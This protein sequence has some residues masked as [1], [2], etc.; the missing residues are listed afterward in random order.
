MCFSPTHHPPNCL[1]PTHPPP[2]IPGAH[3]A[4]PRWPTRSPAPCSSSPASASSSPALGVSSTAAT[5]STVSLPAPLSPSAFVGAG[6]A[7]S[8]SPL[9]LPHGYPWAFLCAAAAVAAGAAAA[10]DMDAH[11]ATCLPPLRCCVQITCWSTSPMPSP[12]CCCSSV[13]VALVH[14]IEYLGSIERCCF[15]WGAARLLPQLRV[16]RCPTLLPNWPTGRSCMPSMHLPA[17]CPAVRGPHLCCWGWG[18]GWGQRLTPL[19][20]YT[21]SASRRWLPLY[22]AEEHADCF[23]AGSPSP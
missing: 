12:S 18:W 3:S 11:A 13:S 9:R 7:F 22:P 10:A 20:V 16:A 4:S 8:F 19:P 23:E 21:P 14:A 6:A 17:C 15:V 2:T 5:S 1:L